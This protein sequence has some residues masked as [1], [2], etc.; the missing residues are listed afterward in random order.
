MFVATL[1]DLICLIYL[2]FIN[3]FKIS[4]AQTELFAAQTTLFDLKKMVSSILNQNR[5]VYHLGQRTEP[6]RDRRVRTGS[7]DRK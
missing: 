2:I 3:I 6:G 5:Q 1:I 7:E 4:A